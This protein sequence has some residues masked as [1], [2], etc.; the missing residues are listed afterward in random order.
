MNKAVDIATIILPGYELIERL[1]DGSRTRVYRGI[2]LSNS[3]QKPRAVAIKFLQQD[4]PSFN[5]L[6]QFRNQ[7]T[8]AKNLNDRGIIQTYSLETY[9]N[10]YALVMEDF[11]GISLR[12]YVENQPLPLPDFLKIAIALAD[13]LNYLYQNRVIH[14]DIKPANILIHPE[15]KEVKLIDFSIASLLPKETQEIK[16]PQGLEG[17]LA[18]LSPE[19]TGR[20]NRGIDYRSD[21]YSLGIT[22]YELLTGQ[23]P[24][25]V[26][27]PLDLVHSHLA[28]SPIS[29]QAVNPDVPL[30]LSEIVMKLMAKNA[31]DRYQ[32][33]LGLK[34][35]LELCWQQLQETGEI[36]NFEIAQRD[37]C[38]RFLIPDK[39]YGREQEV[40]ALLKAFD[41]VA[42]GY[43]VNKQGRGGAP[44]SGSEMIL[45]AGFSG[46]GKTVVVNEVH[47][48][49]VRQRGYFIKG[50]YDQFQRNIPFSALVQAF[51]DLMGQLLSE[52]DTQLQGWKDRILA[53]VGENGQV[54]IDVVPELELI[55]GKQPTA[56]E[57]T[58]TA[59][60]NRFNLLIQKFIKIFAD[61]SHPLVMFI[62]DLQWA[63]SASLNLLKLLMQDTQY[64]L[65]IGAYRNNEVFPAHPFMLTVDEMSKAGM[66]VNTITLQPLSLLDT[67]YL[68]ADTLNCDLSIAQPLTELI[69]QKTIGNP[70]FTTQF[71][72]SL[73]E[74]KLI[75]FTSLSA[76]DQGGWQC[77]IAKVQALT[78]TDDVVE[79]MALQL[80]RL[81][82]ET[83][84]ALK[85]AACI[86][87]EFDLQT[88]A[89]I[90]EKSTVTMATVLWRA[91]QEG[92]VIPISKTYKFFTESASQEEALSGSANPTYRFL[93]DRIQQAAYSLI[94]E[95]KKTVTHLKIGQLLQQSSSEMELE[96]KLFDI[97][98]H[99]NVGKS[100]INQLSQ[101]TELAKLNL[102]AGC[103]ARLATAYSAAMAYCTTAIELLENDCW[104]SQYELTLSLHDAT[105]EVAYLGGQFEKFDEIASITL[106]SAKTLLD[107]IATYETQILVYVAQN[108]LPEAIQSTLSILAKLGIKLPP[109]PNQIQ[110]V[111]GLV[112]T[113]SII[114]RRKPSQL[115]NLTAMSDPI[116][117]AAMRI[118]VIGSSAALIG[119]PNLFPLLI[120]QQINLSVQYG[121][122]AIAA[123]AYVGYGIILSGVVIDIDNGY[124][125]GQ[126][127]LQILER[128]NNK[129][130]ES[131]ALFVV[132]A[133][134]FH[135]KQHLRSTISG[136]QQ[137]YQVGLE[138]GNLE[139]AAWNALFTGFYS[140]WSGDELS[141]LAQTLDYYCEAIVQLKQNTPWLYINI[142]RQAVLN[143]IGESSDPSILYGAAYEAKQQANQEASGDKIGLFIYQIN[144]LYISYLFGDFSGAVK[145]INLAKKYEDVSPGGYVN[146]IFN[147]YSSLVQLALYCT[148]TKAEQRQILRH[149]RQNQKRLK[150]WANFA[151]M[152][153]LHKFDLVEAE[154]YQVQGQ[155][156]EAQDYYDRAIAGAKANKYI[157]EEALANELAAKFY[158]DWGKEKIAAVYMQEAYYCYVRWGANAKVKDLETR[159]PQL[160]NAILQ[161]PKTTLDPLETL[162]NITHSSAQTSVTSN[163]SDTLDFASILKS[164]QALSSIIELDNFLKQLTK[165]ILQNSGADECILVLPQDNFWK[166]RAVSTPE[167]TE[168]LS[169]SLDNNPRVP[170]KLIQY[171]KHT[172]TM[173]VV[174]NLE[175]DLPVIG[176]YLSKH[177]PKSVASLPILHQGQLVGILYLKNQYTAGVFTSDRLRVINFLCT[178][179]AISLENAQ[180]YSDLQ[181]NETRFQNLAA[182]VLGAIYQFRLDKNGFSSFTYMSPS[183]QT[184]YE[185]SSEEILADASTIIATIHPEDITSFQESV[186]QSAKTLEDW[187]WEGRYIT[188]SGKLKWMRGASRPY[189]ESD[190][191]VIWDGLVMDVSDRKKAEQTLQES[192]FRLKQLFEKAADPILLLG[193]QGFIDCNQGAVNLFG[194]STKAQICNLHLSQISPAFQPDG[195]P[196]LEK[197]NAMIHEAIQNG[198]H[199]FEWMHQRADGECF[200]AEVMLTAIPYAE[201]TILHCIV[202]DISDRKQAEA[203][204]TQK[205]Q[206]LAQALENLQHTQIQMIQS[207]KMSALGN[208]VAGIAHEINNPVGFLNGNIKPAGDYI[209]DLFSLIDLYQTEF[210]HPGENIES[211]I[212]AIDL[213]Y[214]RED[215][216]KLIS[217]M[218]AGV[219]RIRDISTSLRTFSRADSDRPVAFNLHHGLDSTILILKHRLK[220]DNS[221]PEIQIIKNYGQIPLIACYAGQL[222]QVF[223]NIIA[224][225]IDA[226]E[227]ANYGRSFAEI[228][229]NPNKITITTMML[230]RHIQ[231]SIM[232]NGNGMTEEI[233]AK[234]FDH[235]FTTKEVGK[236]TGLGLAIAKQIVEEK[237]QGT[238]SV[239]SKLG[240]GTEFMITLPLLM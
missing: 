75:E 159:Y 173:V 175:T 63:D 12:D 89:I 151:P 9:A 143:L 54:L 221:R 205:S 184:L 191:S 213:E 127:A 46:I 24:F 85:L 232:D 50:K 153:T 62:D 60:Q 4:Y 112:K 43:P 158:L 199:R 90:S 17:T 33:A 198:S 162:I 150:K 92:F 25:D 114:G 133:F 57:L 103:K 47:K 55:I 136:F 217:S 209:K 231:I 72:K 36:L 131:K 104:E 176:N 51:R 18:Y 2:Q 168:I 5:E 87:S 235:L 105:A 115:L 48:P 179:A 135:W 183:C 180:L 19:Q 211:E 79:F 163:I 155:F 86:G 206:D 99:L 203:I 26:T 23:L 129:E 107:K 196:S 139:F 15:T 113:K 76:L 130:M 10:S 193:T 239:N 6:L 101:R 67:N 109:T 96:E 125:F 14:K 128:F 216:P 97:V 39:L 215:L 122:A 224:N 141:D 192:E 195:Q 202:R 218:Q 94:P 84:D 95:H 220:A 169:E 189:L 137:G 123:S 8:I 119:Q 61:Q 194:Y 197:A 226:F 65:I 1:Y 182:N 223:M 156:S 234:I 88:L 52:N 37:L 27:D 83:Q 208:L 31:E 32:S 34:Y 30:V 69:Y 161:Q 145:Q 70:F 149:V 222:N 126:L 56:T 181:A 186:A 177:Q 74:D 118:M 42:G 170:T 174:N 142:S 152:N 146:V 117:L 16:N 124:K 148:A 144:Q 190:G 154:R 230:E 157:Q 210:P 3:L 188:P 108:R 7:Y 66:V 201:E 116:K 164:A 11:G 29:V 102:A 49:I 233:K 22:F 167:I 44:G 81:P 219:D 40:Q 93:H 78:S 80:Q 204:I 121:N 172:Q 91:L 140:Y 98:N 120:F 212:E 53:V 200:W 138:T 28:K 58:G 59:A 207:E 111:L 225:A 20:M 64:L 71:L 228:Q 82:R 45:V 165:I 73:Y 77:D 166:L 21:F 134:I 106:K 13:I 100:L 236:G 171:V 132:N 187:H 35:D 238:I 41:R 147:V 38:D 240:Q 237:H 185:I 68:V 227:E 160:L 214:I 178:Q 229:A 110:I